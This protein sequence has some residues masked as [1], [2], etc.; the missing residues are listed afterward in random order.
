M[1]WATLGKKGGGRWIVA[2]KRKGVV[3]RRSPFGAVDC[4]GERRDD[5]RRGRQDNSGLACSVDNS[6][7]NHLSPTSS[8][9][10]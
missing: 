5:K 6:V 9:Q 8:H 7:V 10:S 3:K 1:P 2:F 4:L